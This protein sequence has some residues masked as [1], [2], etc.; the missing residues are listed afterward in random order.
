[1]STK[2]KAHK[3]MHRKT[4]QIQPKP[5]TQMDAPEKYTIIQTQTQ[6][7]VVFYSCFFVFLR[8]E[9]ALVSEIGRAVEGRRSE[10]G[11][12]RVQVQSIKQPE[13]SGRLQI[14]ALVELTAE[15]GIKPIIQITIKV[16][17]WQLRAQWLLRLILATPRVQGPANLISYGAAVHVD[18]VHTH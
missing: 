8:Y 16:E 2:R 4:T 9:L 13:S 14:L 7:F 10:P 3:W 18:P 11:R 17:T 6:V 12:P 1:M 5:T 15:V